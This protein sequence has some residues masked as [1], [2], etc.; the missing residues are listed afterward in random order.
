MEIEILHFTESQA[1]AIIGQ[2]QRGK[3]YITVPHEKVAK[4]LYTKE[5]IREVLNP[6]KKELPMV[7]N[8]LFSGFYLY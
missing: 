6:F 1:V 5:L 8:A 7:S 3:I 4:T 2:L